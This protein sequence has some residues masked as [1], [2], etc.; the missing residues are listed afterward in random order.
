MWYKLL[1]CK[2]L[3]ENP[4][5]VKYASGFE[6]FTDEFKGKST[7]NSQADVIKQYIKEGR[8]SIIDECRELI[9]LIKSND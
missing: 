2:Y 7:V 4:E 9:E 1:W 3:D 6:D 8:K 5:L